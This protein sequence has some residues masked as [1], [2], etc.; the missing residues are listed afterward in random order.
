MLTVDIEG[1]S[2]RYVDAAGDTHIEADFLGYAVTGDVFTKLFDVAF[3]IGDFE[4]IFFEEFSAFGSGGIFPF[5]LLGEELIGVG[6]PIALEASGF[7]GGSGGGAVF[8]I[9]KEEA[10]IDYGKFAIKFFNGFVNFR[11]NGGTAG[12]LIVGIFENQD[13][14]VGVTFDMIANL[15]IARVGFDD[16]IE[17]I[18]IEVGGFVVAVDDYIGSYD[19]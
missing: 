16:G 9:G 19:Y 1:W 6:F 12:T 15:A 5:G 10:A 7:G 8:V 3:A 4:E 14:S 11:I 2:A 18:V 17:I 13:R